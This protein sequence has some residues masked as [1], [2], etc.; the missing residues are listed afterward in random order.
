[1]EP[2]FESKQEGLKEERRFNTN[3]PTAACVQ[4]REQLYSSARKHEIQESI[5]SSR[6]ENAPLT[7]IKIDLAQ[8]ARLM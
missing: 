1:M 5:V 4:E 8:N 3:V 6:T 7:V 2:A